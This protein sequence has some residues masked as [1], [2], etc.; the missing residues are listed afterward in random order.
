M[1][2]LFCCL[3]MLLFLVGC[4]DY[5]KSFSEVTGAY[6][7]TLS[8]AN[9]TTRAVTLNVRAGSYALSARTM[10]SQERARITTGRIAHVRKNIVQIGDSQFQVKGDSELRLLNEK[11][12]VVKASTLKKI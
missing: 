11:G 8:G 10:D 12:K 7:G 5:A 9:D 1:K 6:A 2:K 3:V 4:A